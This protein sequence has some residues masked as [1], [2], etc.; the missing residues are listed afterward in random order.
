MLFSDLS[1]TTS[2]IYCSNS[3]ALRLP[4]GNGVMMALSSVS[5]FGYEFFLLSPSF[6]TS[7]EVE[8]IMRFTEGSRF[9]TASLSASRSSFGHGFEADCAN[10]RFLRCTT[11]AVS[12]IGT[13]SSIA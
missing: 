10:W 6:F 8:L 11:L 12:I 4:S 1:A 9:L 5:S 7:T 2:F 3:P 13:D